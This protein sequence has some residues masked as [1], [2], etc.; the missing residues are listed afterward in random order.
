MVG[1]VSLNHNRC[2][3][4]AVEY[5][6]PAVKSTVIPVLVTGIHS[7]TVPPRQRFRMVQSTQRLLYLFAVT[8]TPSTSGS[9]SGWAEPV[10]M[11]TA[12]GT[13]ADGAAR[14]SSDFGLSR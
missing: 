1:M 2:T 9:F 8:V 12:T 3:D 6:Q 10:A 13:G 4:G 14:I 7:S 5:Y 11:S